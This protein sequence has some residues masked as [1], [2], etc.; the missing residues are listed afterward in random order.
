[1]PTFDQLQDIF[2][3]QELINS[4]SYDLFKS[5]DKSNFLKTKENAERQDASQRAYDMVQ[6]SRDAGGEALRPI[7]KV[8]NKG[9]AEA[10]DV[11]SLGPLQDK[12]P[13]LEELGVEYDENFE[14]NASIIEHLQTQ[15]KVLGRLGLSVPEFFF[16]AGR[17]AYKDR[18]KLYDAGL[19]MEE[20][21]EQEDFLTTTLPAL[22]TPLEVL[23]L[24]L[25]VKKFPKYASSAFYAV[26]HKLDDVIQDLTG[27]IDEKAKEDNTMPEVN[28]PEGSFEDIFKTT[29]MA[30]GGDPDQDNSEY[31]GAFSNPN[32]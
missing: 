20:I 19:S 31:G 26:S 25:P 15:A 22:I 17:D 6:E 18:E 8:I 27:K 4:P 24:G 2:T 23:G 14:E 3:E 11:L 30:K 1:M 13:T 32:L 7:N 16:G 29:N 5:K 10:T 12:L 9:L 28:L 21:E